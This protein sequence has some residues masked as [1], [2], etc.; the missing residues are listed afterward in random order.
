MADAHQTIALHRVRLKYTLISLA[1]QSRV[2]TIAG[3]TEGQLTL[4]L[5]AGLSS[6][7]SSGS[8]SGDGG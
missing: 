5:G 7:S 6:T 8:E 1:R 4:F 3:F 2:N